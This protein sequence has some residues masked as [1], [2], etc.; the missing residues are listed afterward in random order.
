MRLQE[1]QGREHGVIEVVE[2]GG[3]QGW[4]FSSDTVACKQR[5]DPADE[6]CSAG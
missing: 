6:L 2:P 5:C 1:R 3:L 4:R